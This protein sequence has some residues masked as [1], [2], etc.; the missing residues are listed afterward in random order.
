[1]WL[2]FT[3]PITSSAIFSLFYCFSDTEHIFEL[4]LTPIFKREN[5]SLQTDVKYKN[6]KHFFLSIKYFFFYSSWRYSHPHFLDTKNTLPKLKVVF[7][8]TCKL[9][10]W[11]PFSTTAHMHISLHDLIFL[12]GKENDISHQVS[13]KSEWFWKTAGWSAT[14][15][16]SIC[17]FPTK[18]SW[19]GKIWLLLVFGQFSL[20]LF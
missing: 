10:F 17:Y 7:F 16:M 20:N 11:W 5:K 6:I 9:I 13:W 1:M 12:A 8:N 19:K 14:K 2:Y 15:N 3:V 4:C 18:S